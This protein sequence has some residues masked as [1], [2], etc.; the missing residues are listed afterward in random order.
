M[1]EIIMNTVLEEEEHVTEQEYIS[2]DEVVEGTRDIIEKH[3]EALK[4]LGN[5]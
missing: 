3:F 5:A 2:H 4:A 1:G